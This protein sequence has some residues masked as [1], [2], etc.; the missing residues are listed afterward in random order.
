MIAKVFSCNSLK[1]LQ[2]K[3]DKLLEDPNAHFLPLV[4]PASGDAKRIMY[5]N[6]GLRKWTYQ[7]IT[8]FDVGVEWY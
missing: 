8:R 7:G 6:V 2:E 3:I 5:K 4:I 1:K